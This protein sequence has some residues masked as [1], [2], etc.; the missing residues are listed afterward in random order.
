MLTCRPHLRPLQKSRP[1][2]AIHLVARGQNCP[3]REVSALS[4]SF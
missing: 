4:L 1:A 3:L 2:H